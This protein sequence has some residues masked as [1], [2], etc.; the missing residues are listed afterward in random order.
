MTSSTP[1]KKQVKEPWAPKGYKQLK[2]TRKTF[3]EFLSVIKGQNDD[4]FIV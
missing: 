2:R 4:D 3:R 1:L